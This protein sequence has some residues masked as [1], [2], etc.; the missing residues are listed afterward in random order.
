MLVRSDLNKMPARGRQPNQ[1]KE[2]QPTPISHE[3]YIGPVVTINLDS[4]YVDLTYLNTTIHMFRDSDLNHIRILYDDDAHQ[5]M[6][7]PLASFDQSVIDKLQELEYPESFM[8]F[9]DQVTEDW[10]VRRYQK[11]L[12]GNR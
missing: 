10:F 5:C 4:D 7:I 1:S 9:P 12:L 8:P 11:G 6:V 3:G 2:Q